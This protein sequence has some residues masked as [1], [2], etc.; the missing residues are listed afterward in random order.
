MTG[1]ISIPCK[2]A[3]W[4][5]GQGVRT[6]SVG[7]V[8]LLALGAGGVWPLQFL[9]AATAPLLYASAVWLFLFLCHLTLRFSKSLHSYPSPQKGVN[10]IRASHPFSAGPRFLLKDFKLSPRFLPGKA[11]HEA[12]QMVF[13]DIFL[14]SSYKSTAAWRSWL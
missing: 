11:F 6:V 10:I 8:G 2:P 12:F 1:I 9:Y 4:V 7:P 5:Y 3:K 14:D 13:H